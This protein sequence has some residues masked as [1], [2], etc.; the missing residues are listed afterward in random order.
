MTSRTLKG[1][2]LAAG[3]ALCIPTPGMAAQMCSMNF[4][5]VAGKKIGTVEAGDGLH[6]SINF[7]VDRTKRPDAETQ[8]YFVDDLIA[9]SGLNVG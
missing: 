6:G 8:S 5:F 4:Y 9:L 1:V 7:V 3:M 2:L